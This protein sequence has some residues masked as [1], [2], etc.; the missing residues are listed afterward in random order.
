MYLIVL[1]RDLKV[2][3]VGVEDMVGTWASRIQDQVLLAEPA[4]G[5]FRCRCSHG[6]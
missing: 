1:E 3:K 6:A 5:S 2:E 4:F